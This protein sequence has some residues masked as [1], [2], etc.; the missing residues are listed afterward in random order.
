MSLV[1]ALNIGRQA[2]AAQQAAI[3]TTGNN[4]SNAGNADYA[5]QVTSLSATRD[6]R[7]QSGIFVGTGV[8]VD[9]IRRQVDDALEGRLRAATSDSESA[10]V[11]QQQLGQVESVLNELGDGD[12]S[13]KMS[14]FFGAWSN[15]ANK[16]Q[17]A[18]LRQ[19][20][21][22]NGQ[23]VAGWLNDARGQLNDL[24]T[25]I[26]QRLP[27]LVNQADSLA[28]QIAGLNETIATAEGGQGIA[29]G[30]R[31][32][33][34]A[35]V[36]QLSA[37][38]DV[39]TV[40][41][42]NGVLNVYVGSEPLVMGTD[43][44]GLTVVQTGTA[45]A[46][47]PE[48]R[49]KS[50]LGT[51][52][53]KTG[54]IG[55]LLA[56]REAVDS[57]AADTDAVAGSLIYELNKV[58]AAGQGLAGFDAVKATNLVADPTAALND[59]KA[60]LD[61]PSANGSFVVHVKDKST[62]LVTST[63]IKV[64]L[65]GVGGNDTSL[66]DLKTALDGVA[67]VNAAVDSAGQLSVSADSS[68]VELSFSQDSSGALASLGVNTFFSGKNA[69]D[70]AV[71]QAVKDNPSLLAAA[72]NGQAG[73]NGTARLIAALETQPVAALGGQSLTERYEGTANRVAS[74]AAAAK[75]D[76]EAAQG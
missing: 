65:D 9:A 26:D 56:A 17:D 51:V 75:T 18:G 37:L 28:T 8:Q 14:A 31:D 13:T 76:A 40:E 42:P 7:V 44:R 19:V 10:Q 4:I 50:N 15:L 70:I 38:M 74:A 35:V 23:A 32:Q 39:K 45:D 36:K 53:L 43:N 54:Q 21:V 66:N 3:Q 29:N 6:Q 22:Q 16:P 41:Q 48:V 1:G 62:G 57:V 30:L 24:Q 2:L 11:V 69:T 25:T 47:V 61:H 46:P 55:G 20:V 68:A 63:L 71:N 52:S 64:D 5:R 49:F 12:L 58:H 73:D 59:E 27:D 60:G 33:R 72:K 34:D 67:G